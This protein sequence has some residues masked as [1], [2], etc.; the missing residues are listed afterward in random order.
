MSPLSV[1]TQPLEEIWHVPKAQGESS[2]I[3]LS[4]LLQIGQMTSSYYPNVPSD[5]RLWVTGLY[6][7]LNFLGQDKY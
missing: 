2:Q 3:E 6:I 5:V 1:T 7:R 4:L